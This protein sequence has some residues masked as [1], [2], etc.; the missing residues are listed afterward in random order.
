LHDLRHT[1]ASLLIA[2]NESPKKIQ[3]LLGHQPIKITMDTCGHLYPEENRQ[4]VDSLD[5]ATICNAR[6]TNK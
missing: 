1:F 2:Q 5:D 3:V 6:A 4:A